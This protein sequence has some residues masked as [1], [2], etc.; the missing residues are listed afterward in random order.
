MEKMRWL[1]VAMLLTSGTAPSQS[2]VNPEKIAGILKRIMLQREGKPSV[3]CEVTPIR[4]AL[5]WGFR[6]QAGYIA[7]IP[8]NQFP[9]LGHRWAIIVK[10]TPEEGEGRPVYMVTRI[11]L[12]NIPETK[13]HAEMGGAYL[14][15]QGRYQ[16]EWNLVDE[17][18]RVCQKDWTVKVELSRSDRKV[19]V[20]MPPNTV[21]ELSLRDSIRVKRDKADMRPVRITVLLHAT[22]LSPRRS[23]LRPSDTLMLLGSLSALLERLPS[24][25]VRLVVFN[26]EQ[27]KEILRRDGFDPEA[28]DQ[29]AQ[30]MNALELGSVDYTVLQNR[31]GHLQLLAELVNR[32]ITATE[33]SDVVVFI[34]P[35]S[36]YWDKLP[37]ANLEKARD[38]PPHFFYFQFKPFFRRT[39]NTPDSIQHLVDKLKGKTA[40][41]HSPGEFAKAIEQLESRVT[42]ARLY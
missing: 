15:G 7:R 9:G 3:K 8:L 41:I 14:M 1:F 26:L 32:E 17:K 11:D 25:S 21:R 18:N 33:P 35:M 36:R 22:P 24:R 6:F 29:V 2:I 12:P 19:Q 16:V 31:G 20:A 28:L 37:Q 40:I 39:A 34:G 38:A 42:K 27:Q 23:K 4:P 30:S 10:I 13:L 5:N